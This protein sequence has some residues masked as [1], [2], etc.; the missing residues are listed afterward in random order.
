MSASGTIA[1]AALKIFSPEAIAAAGKLAQKFAPEAFTTIESSLPREAI[2]LLDNVHSRN[3]YLAKELL[4]SDKGIA[5]NL[6]RLSGHLSES[7]PI[8]AKKF[9][10]YADKL[11]KNVGLDDNEISFLQS[12]LKEISS[13]TEPATTET[14]RT[15]TAKE[16]STHKLSREDVLDAVNLLVEG[17]VEGEKKIALVKLLKVQTVIPQT[18]I[19]EH[20][21]GHPLAK[22]LEEG[23]QTTDTNISS[24]NVATAVIEPIL[25]K[26]KLNLLSS[27]SDT[28]FGSDSTI[29]RVF[30]DSNLTELVESQ[31]SKID[32]QNLFSTAQSILNKERIKLE[33]FSRFIHSMVDITI[34]EP[35]KSNLDKGIQ[36]LFSNY[37]LSIETPTPQAEP[38]QPTTAPKPEEAAKSQDPRDAEIERLKTELERN[39]SGRSGEPPDTDP[40]GQILHGVSSIVL[41]EFSNMS[42]EMGWLMKMYLKFNGVEKLDQDTVKNY[43]GK[44]TEHGFVRELTSYLRSE[45]KSSALESITEG[46]QTAVKWIGRLVTIS[47]NTPSWV[48]DGISMAGMALDYSAE[49]L[50]GIPIIGGLLRIPFLR[51]GIVGISQFAGRFTKDLQLIKNATENLVGRPKPAERSGET[52]TVRHHEPELQTAAA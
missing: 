16:Q 11:L 6:L 15:E 2:A 13:F 51:K 40:I 14:V 24:A 25:D 49:M 45:D 4:S 7:H 48:L 18:Y 29:S 9:E 39:R 12:Q 28:I 8:I 27:V 34:P 33:P 1:Q 21:T 46:N 3:T 31:V 42:S 22:F 20:I 47:A 5:H 30:K 23:S 36:T 32:S 44:F 17:K 35:D 26:D 19:E 10:S 50:H 38:A 41:G 37:H 43:L 52:E